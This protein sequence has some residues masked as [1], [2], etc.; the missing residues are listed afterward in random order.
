V[1]NVRT[2]L[3]G[4]GYAATRHLLELGHRRIAHLTHERYLENR[5]S[6]EQSTGYERAMA[7][8]GLEPRVF[9]HSLAWYRI[10]EPVSFYDCAGDGV[11][12]L[13]AAARLPTAVVCYECYGAFR[14]IE[15]ATARGLRV[16]ADLAVVGGNDLDICQIAT[17]RIS[18]LRINTHGIGEAAGE[19]IIR[20][21]AGAPGRDRLIPAELVA[22][23]SSVPAGGADG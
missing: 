4:M 20:M 18:T 5:D 13:L 9:T 2:D 23:G 16:P 17:P 11:A 3:V 22:R 15:M 21:L 7:E 14:V 10:G 19:E 1:P 12:R 8:A 6:H